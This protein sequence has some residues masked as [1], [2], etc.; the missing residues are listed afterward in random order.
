[1]RHVGEGGEGDLFYGGGG[2]GGEHIK[3]GG[4]RARGDYY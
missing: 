2:G 1:M 3:R 4:G